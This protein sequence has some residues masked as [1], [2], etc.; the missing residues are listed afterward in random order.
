MKPASAPVASAT[1][2]LARA[3]NSLITTKRGMIAVAASMASGT[4]MEA[5]SE[6]IVPETLTT[7][8]KPAA[9]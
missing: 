5:P 7:G 4:A 9:P 8:R 2:R 6:V 3:C 1:A